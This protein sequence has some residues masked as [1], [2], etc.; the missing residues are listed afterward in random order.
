MKKILMAVLFALPVAV[1][2]QKIGHVNSAAVVQGMNEYS[3][4]QTEITSLQ[5]QF[6]DELQRKRTDI[7]AKS[8]T[9]EKEKATLSETLRSYREQEIQK[10]IEEYQQFEQTSSQ[11]LQKVYEEKM[12]VVRDKVMDAVKEVGTAGG[13]AYVLDGASIPFIGAG[14]ADLTDQVKAKLGVK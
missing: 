5:K 6:E 1:S 3:T 8:E 12:S 14:A 9:Y 4:M 11:E 10:A 2:A 13:Y 7:Q